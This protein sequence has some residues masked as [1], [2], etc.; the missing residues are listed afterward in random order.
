VRV[1]DDVRDAVQ[2]LAASD[3]VSVSE[4]VRDLLREQTMPLQ[5]RQVHGDADA[6]ESL[7]LI[8]RQVLS[9]LHRILGRLVPDQNGDEEGT[10]EDQVEIAEI[11]EHGYAGEYWRTVAG[12]A[13]ELSMRDSRRVIDILQLFRIAT[14]SMDRLVREGVPVDADLRR[15]L[16]FRGFDHNDA[17]ESQMAR[18]TRHLMADGERWS[19]LQPAIRENDGGNSHMPVLALYMRMLG[20]YR[21][22]M[23]AR[24]RSYDIDDY[25]LSLGELQALAAARV[26]PD[27]RGRRL[28]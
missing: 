11:L 5:Q 24:S 25:L 1:D 17:L 14:F 6:P 27:G 9:L 21:R 7:R 18:Y 20:E 8:D 28:T 15:A 23:D 3:G 19:E 10:R 2:Q 22:I 13:T 12:F 4:Y 16:T 26:H